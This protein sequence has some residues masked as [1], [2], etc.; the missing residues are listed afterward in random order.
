MVNPDRGPKTSRARGAEVVAGATERER[1]SSGPKTGG[2]GQA[3]P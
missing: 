1:C 3:I 2:L